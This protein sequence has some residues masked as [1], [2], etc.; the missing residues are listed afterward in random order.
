M[1]CD[2]CP[3]LLVFQIIEN[4]SRQTFGVGREYHLEICRGFPSEFVAVRRWKHLGETEL[5]NFL[6]RVAGGGFTLT[7]T[8]ALAL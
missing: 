5:V 3:V 2:V 8:L 4:D 1:C 6:D 7:L